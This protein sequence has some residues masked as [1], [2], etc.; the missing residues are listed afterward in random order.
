MSEFFKEES[1]PDYVID[2]SAVRGLYY[3]DTTRGA[4]NR[5][6]LKSTLPIST[7]DSFVRF[8]ET[9]SGGSI[10]KGNGIGSPMVAIALK[11][12]MAAIS[13]FRIDDA[14]SDL[15]Y[16]IFPGKEKEVADNLE[17]LANRLK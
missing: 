3:R 8:L 5:K 11:L 13:R 2:A 6:L 7:Y 12:T 16:I 17:A 1:A 10:H 9:S 14:I 15:R 4:R